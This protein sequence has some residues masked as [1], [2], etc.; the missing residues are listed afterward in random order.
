MIFKSPLFNNSAL[1]FLGAALG[2][3]AA[4]RQ[5]VCG[6]AGSR[7]SGRR[8]CQS[9]ALFA[10]RNS[11]KPARGSAQPL[12]G[13]LAQLSADPTWSSGVRI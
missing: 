8:E 6:T 5:A 13:A 11:K 3:S 7:E 1:C 4:A 9:Q 2:L 12:K 10:G